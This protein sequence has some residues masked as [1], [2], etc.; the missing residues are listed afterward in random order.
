MESYLP[1]TVFAEHYR[2]MVR[3]IIRTYQLSHSV[4]ADVVLVLLAVASAEGFLHLSLML[5]LGDERL[6]DYGYQWKGSV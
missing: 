4:H 1:Q 6:L 2:E 5:T 3:H